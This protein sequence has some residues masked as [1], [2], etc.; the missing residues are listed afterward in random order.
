MLLS[1]AAIYG[2][3]RM[4]LAQKGEAAIPHDVNQVMTVLHGPER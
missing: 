1:F 2:F 4:E 3:S